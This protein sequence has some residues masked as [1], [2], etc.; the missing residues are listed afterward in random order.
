MA[1]EKPAVTGVVTTP[2]ALSRGEW[3][4]TVN[5]VDGSTGVWRSSLISAAF[6]LRAY[7]RAS[8]ILPVKGWNTAAPICS[9]SDD[10]GTV[11]DAAVLATSTPFTN[12]CSAVPSYEPAR[13]V[14][15]VGRI[16]DGL[17]S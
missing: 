4:P 12:K 2:S 14:H 8:S 3:T 15:R 5:G 7:T 9:G 1:L 11:P 17:R 10:A 16:G 13:C 6:K